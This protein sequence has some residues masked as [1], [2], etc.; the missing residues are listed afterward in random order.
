[1]AHAVVIV[2]DRGVFIVVDRSKEENVG[3]NLSVVL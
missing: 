2:L 1:M 3:T